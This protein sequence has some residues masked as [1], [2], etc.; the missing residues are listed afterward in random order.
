MMNNLSKP[1]SIYVHIPFCQSKCNYCA[2]YSLPNCS[3]SIKQSYTEAIIRQIK[4]F[5][6]SRKI[7]SVYFGGGTPPVLG[8]THI[9]SILEE[10]K[11][12]FDL[13]GNCEITLE[14]NP[15]SVS[16]DELV[17]LRNA[18]FNR[19]SMGLQSSDNKELSILGRTYTFEKYMQTLDYACRAGFENISTDIIFAIPEQTNKSLLKTLDDAVL[20]VVS[21]ISI[22][23]LS[24]EK[25]TP[26]YN[27]RDTL[28]LPDEDTEEEMYAIICKIMRIEN[29]KHY[30]ISS[31][32][33]QGYESKHNLH[34]WNCG[35]YI[36]FGAA[37]HS[38]FGGKRFSNIAD[39]KK[40]ISLAD[41]IYYSPTDFYIQ[42]FLTDEDRY[43]EQIMLGLRTSK[44]IKATEK[45]IEKSQKL[46]K[47]GFMQLNDGFLALT[48]T[49]YRV[50]NSI[51]TELIW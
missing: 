20:P 17:L 8:V 16:Q 25:G 30:E 41:N 29:F 43:T 11:S 1:L 46:I 48:E 28:N 24:I 18:G 33:R 31:F 44:G 38:Y 35:E 12:N 21:H 23:S 50:S 40:Y 19:L 2:F 39:I 5:K 45:L 13:D 10:I 42:P 15:N 7:K 4:A 36:G 51:I 14:A 9:I 47:Y 49:G 26:F 6:T 37:A 3:Y 22:Y 32:T 34:Y 27:M